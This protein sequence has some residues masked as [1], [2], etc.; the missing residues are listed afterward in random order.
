MG[1]KNGMNVYLVRFVTYD[2]M[3][4]AFRIT[5]RSPEAAAKHKKEPGEIQS[6]MKIKG[7]VVAP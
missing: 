5:A 3:E 1:R 7:I 2:G 6:V 4:K